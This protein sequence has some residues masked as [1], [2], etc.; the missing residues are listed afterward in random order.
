MNSC[1]KILIADD[2]KVEREILRDYLILWGYKVY[3][4]VN[5]KEAIRMF[6]MVRPDLV[7]IDGVMP[8]MNGY[9]TC[10]YLH[11]MRPEFKIP[12]IV[13]TAYDNIES[14][15]RAFA[16][17]AVEYLTKPIY[18]EALKYRLQRISATKRTELALFKSEEKLQSIFNNA[19]AGVA[20]G[21]SCGKCIYANKQVADMLGYSIEELH[22]LTLSDV[23]YHEDWLKT[24][25]NIEKM[26]KKEISEYHIEKR[27]IRKDKTIFWGKLYV[28]AVYNDANHIEYFVGVIIDIT[29]NKQLEGQIK[30]Q[31]KYLL[32]LNEAS[33]CNFLICS[34]FIFAP[35]G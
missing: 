9:A 14:V 3:E 13:I 20:M 7:I 6:D 29:D 30:L 22:Q 28:S 8:E 31:N 18:W 1:F 16:A 19:V 33:C 4:A 34:I 26:L 21:D 17:G 2:S 12:V 24:K 11:K 15:A 25:E 5:G 35:S 23:T 32:I 27:F 10:A